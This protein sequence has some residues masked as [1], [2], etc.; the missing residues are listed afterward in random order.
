MEEETREM[1]EVKQKIHREACMST[2]GMT[3]ICEW[4]LTEGEWV[5]EY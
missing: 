5:T 3:R 2:F 1:R 4:T